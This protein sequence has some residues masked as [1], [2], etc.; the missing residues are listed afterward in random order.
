MKKNLLALF[1]LLLLAAP[2]NAAQ[3]AKPTCDKPNLAP[4][5][6][7][8]GAKTY[9]FP[10]S[11]FSDADWHTLTYTATQLDGSDLPSWLNFTPSTR[12]FSGNPPDD[13]TTSLELKIT[14]DDGHDETEVCPITLNLNSINDRPT[15]RNGIPDRV[16]S[17]STRQ[18]LQF[19]SFAFR[20]AD[21]DP[22]TY[23]AKRSDG[24][25]L[26]TWLR[27]TPQ[28]RTFA[29]T[30]PA[31]AAS[32]TIRVTARDGHGGSVGT[33]FTLTFPGDVTNTLE[34][35]F[36]RIPAGTFTMGSPADEEGRNL[37]ERSHA[38]TISHAFYMQT[39]EVT[40]G[41]W[42]SVMGNNPSYFSS[43][44]DSCPVEQVSWND[45]QNFLSLMNARGEGTY[46]LPT[47]AEW[48]YAA[49]AG[50][51]TPFSFGVS[52]INIGNFAWFWNNAASTTH[53]VGQKQPNPWG[54][55]DMHG[56]VWEWVADRY[57]PF[58]LTAMTDPQGPAFGPNRVYRGGGSYYDAARLRSA[59]RS[60]NEP[61]FRYFNLGFRLVRNDS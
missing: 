34:M 48:E 44:G 9:T 13:G 27:F 37:D 32:L 33:T 38:V 17:R 41:Q 14:A 2:W 8:G 49:R 3:A 54:L 51:R 21:G 6:S 55:F 11:M 57:G 31:D 29:G 4:T 56:N 43:C 61:G 47:E 22:L 52:E 15:V 28:T 59:Y 42:R 18:S 10:A 39:T 53:P 36:K 35:T 26:P 20:D 45:I 19:S 30:P 16:W 40:Q 25:A 58:N 12:T 60:Q 5:W 24:S 50:T 7:G 46:R 1:S 23:T